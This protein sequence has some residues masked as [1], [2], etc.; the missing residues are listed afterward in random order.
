MNNRRRLS[1]IYIV[2]VLSLGLSSVQLSLADPDA[3]ST[4]P[5][6]TNQPSATPAPAPAP[7]PE[8][9]PP[10]DSGLTYTVKHGDS[11]WSVAHKHHTTVVALRQ[12]N[13]LTSDDLKPKQVLKLP[14]PRTKAGTPAKSSAAPATPVQPSASVVPKKKSTPSYAK[15]QPVQDFDIP[16]STFASCPVPVPTDDDGN[17]TASFTPAT[18]TKSA[19][20]AQL[21][22]PDELTADSTPA[23]APAPAPV[24]Q[25]APLVHATPAPLPLSQPVAQVTPDEQTSSSDA[26]LTYNTS[27]SSKQF[28]RNPPTL[29]ASM[30]TASS[31]DLGSRFLLQA[32]ALGAMGIS[33]DESWHPPRESQSW[34]MDCSNTSRYLYKVTTGILLP[35][36][37]SDQYYYLQQQNKAWDVPDASNGYADCNYLRRNLKVGDLLFWENT[38]RP[39]RQPPITHV[40]IFLGTNERGQWIM[41]GSQSSRGGEHNRRH[42]GPDIYVF[43]PTQPSGGYTTWLGLVHHKGRFCA[44]GRPL[45]ADAAKLALVANN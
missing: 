25:P 6:A 11:L 29:T 32:R 40:M 7:V 37:A 34:V 24:R 26:S 16:A 22:S 15:A 44:F 8:G 12:L 42:G 38:Y 10:V 17:S 18:E 30:P 1:P 20:V 33:Y 27:S 41:A 13:N 9:P 14:A 4:P 43:D 31:S 28:N 2:A 35:R 5:P 39:E 19:P 36:T 21:V 3:S 45:E 23:P